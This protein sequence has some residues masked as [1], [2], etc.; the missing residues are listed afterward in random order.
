MI[1]T[2]TVQ[3]RMRGRRPIRALI[4]ALALV[5]IAGCGSSDSKYAWREQVRLQDGKLLLVER[6][7]RFKENWVAGGGG[8]SFNEGMTLRIVQSPI[9][10]PS[11]TWSDRLVP[12]VLEY[13]PVKHEWALIVTFFHC[14]SWYEL[15][16]P[17]LPYAEYRYRDGRWIRQALSTQWI[18]HPAN[19]L[20][21]DP[22]DKA[23]IGSGD[24]LTVERK[25][26]IIEESTMAPKYRRVVDQWKT[27]C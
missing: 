23:A 27:G 8:G 26:T 18:G 10:A 1:A 21:T 9:P 19:V 13:D 11:A 22:S 16:R 17:A 24:V 15:G 14:D 2:N 25:S 6:T 20:P 3:A 7:A 4:T 5:T 12:L